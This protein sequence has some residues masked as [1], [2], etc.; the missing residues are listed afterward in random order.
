M[1]AKAT[2]FSAH[3]EHFY[4]FS[5]NLSPVEKIR[6]QTAARVQTWHEKFNL[7]WKAPYIDIARHYFRE[8]NKNAS[9]QLVLMRHAAADFKDDA[10]H[11]NLLI[12]RFITAFG[13][14]G[15]P[16][17][18]TAVTEGPPD[19]TYIMTTASTPEWSAVEP[20]A[21]SEVQ[22]PRSPAIGSPDPSAIPQPPPPSS[23]L[24]SGQIQ[25][26]SKYP[27]GNRT[28]QFIR[29]IFVGFT[30]VAKV[31]PHHVTATLGQFGMGETARHLSLPGER[32]TLDQILLSMWKHVQENSVDLENFRP[33]IQHI[34]NNSSDT[35]IWEEVFSLVERIRSLI[36]SLQSLPPTRRGTPVKSSSNKFVDTE[37]RDVVEDEVFQEIKS[38]I[39][40][41]VEG[42]INKYF[43]DKNLNEVQKGVLDG[44][45]KAYD[46]TEWEEFPRPPDEM[47]VWKWL[48]SLEERYLPNAPHK[49]H[50]TKTSS[51]FHGRKGQMDVFIQN[52]DIIPAENFRYKDVLVVGELK[53]TFDNSKF[54]S[55]LLQ[56]ARHVRAIFNDFP[57]RLFI[58][59]FT[60]CGST[61]EAWIFDR[62][63]GYSSGPFD[64]NKDH[65]T[66]AAVFSGYLTMNRDALGLDTFMEKDTE[67]RCSIIVNSQKEEKL[68]VTLCDP[69]SKNA[70]IVSRATACYKT[71]NNEVVKFSWVPKKRRLEAE[72]LEK[73]LES[74]VE[75]VVRLVGSRQITSISELREGLGFPAAH[76]FKEE[77]SQQHTPSRI[78][79]SKR[80]K[81]K[82]SS[83][84]T[85]EAVKAPKR[86][87]QRNVESGPAAD[88][89]IPIPEHSEMDSPLDKAWIDRIYS[90]T[91]VSPAGDTIN[92]FKT[93]EQLLKTLR[94]AIE[95]HWSLLD[96]GR[97]LHR[98]ISPNNI[99][100]TGDGSDGLKGMLI[101]LDLAKFLDGKPSGAQH[102]TGTIQ[103]MAIEVLRGVD[104]TYR[105]DLESFFY[106]L[107]WLCAQRSWEN[108][109]YGEDE[110]QPTKSFLHR[111]SVGNYDLICRVK[112]GDMTEMV[113]ETNLEEFPVALAPIKPLCRRF[114]KILFGDNMSCGTPQGDPSK[115]YRSIISAFNEAIAPIVV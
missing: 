57:T 109:L 90:C 39:F 81:R 6:N 75:G 2:S 4:L 108:G 91:V 101:D 22:S 25:I 88:D 72:Y 38:C 71:A 46:G 9:S 28:L 70:A 61:M 66:F 33:L 102:I 85:P 98:D 48:T 112:L 86:S 35:I 44:L 29:S 32:G 77:V 7:R 96:K 64:I 68:Q 41:N 63:G 21:P 80:R 69:L 56:L 105:H 58:H 92:G 76:R 43:G 65:K 84:I 97:I 10:S 51:Q 62:A 30:D 83:D 89:N 74:G 55:V 8:V 18:A 45:N 17:N 1:A 103:F 47:S 110:R 94:D 50:N 82:S 13:I 24:N 42:F 34:L 31:E 14:Q 99:L 27:L 11:I 15:R 67:G 54:K 60:I 20:V 19:V 111:W 16:I 73:V 37:T 36:P 104:H 93:V 113:F 53:M 59:A 40:R 26:I 78:V 3:N 23:S 5:Q 107:L 106:V 100:M 49:L 87:R 52:G 114:R 115:V 12:T 79:S 95:A